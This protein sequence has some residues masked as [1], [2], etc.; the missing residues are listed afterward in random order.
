VNDDMWFHGKEETWN[1]LA[2][3]RYWQAVKADHQ[4]V[5]REMAALDADRIAA[6]TP[7][8][9][10]QWLYDRYF[11]WKFTAANRLATTRKLL[12]DYR[13][14]DPVC[15][16]LGAWQH[17]LFFQ[18]DRRDATKGLEIATRIPGLGVIGASGLLA[19]L[20]PHNFGT[21]DQ[22]VVDALYHVRQL[23]EHDNIKRIHDRKSSTLRIEEGALLI[24]ILRRQADDLNRR[25]GTTRWTPRRV[26]MALWGDRS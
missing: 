7:T 15:Q 17:E 22:F 1:H 11:F 9:F 12:A 5:E 25:F 3:E 20:F 6:L 18:F 2:D 8:E 14:R 16:D 23:P 26:D 13:Q 19:V 24:G 21:V 4:E 10:Y